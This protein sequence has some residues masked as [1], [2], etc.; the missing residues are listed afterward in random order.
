MAVLTLPDVTASPS[1]TLIDEVYAIID[2]LLCHERA[3]RFGAAFTARFR[4]PHRERRKFPIKGI[5]KW[6]GFLKTERR[7]SRCPVSVCGINSQS[8]DSYNLTTCQR[9]VSLFRFRFESVAAV[10]WF[11]VLLLGGRIVGGALAFD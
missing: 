1:A 11:A 10:V 4:A 6:I 9:S 5:I 7:S 3:S 2:L 8:G